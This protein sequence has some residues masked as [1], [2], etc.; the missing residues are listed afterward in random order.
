MANCGSSAP[1]SPYG[2]IEW[3]HDEEHSGNYTVAQ[4]A[5]GK[6]PFDKAAGRAP[7]IPTA[8]GSED[9]V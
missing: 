5:A 7:C 6:V 1:P 4:M 3:N 8:G 9:I 2:E